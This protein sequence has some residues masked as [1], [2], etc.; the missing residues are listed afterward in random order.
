M[1]TKRLEKLKQAALDCYQEMF[2]NSTPK[3]DFKKLMETSPLN[4]RGQIEIPFMNYGLEE[5][6]YDEI[7]NSFLNDK[8]LKMTKAEKDDFRVTINLGCSPR[9]IYDKKLEE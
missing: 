5:K 7:L 1:K 9:I 6:K 4:E 3:A 8:K 2:A